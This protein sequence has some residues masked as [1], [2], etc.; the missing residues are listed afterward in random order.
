MH[1]GCGDG[2]MID[3]VLVVGLG[4]IGQRHLRLLRTRLPGS[5]I[6]VLRHGCCKTPVEGADV[7]VTSLEKALAF[8]PQIAVIATPAPFH[9]ETALALAEGGTHLL[10]EKPMAASALQAQA[11]TTA[12]QAA[13]VVLQVGYNLRQLSSLVAYRV[14]LHS[15]QIGRVA[16]VRAEV[17]QYLPDW[18]PGQDWR[19]SVS[20][21]ADLGGGVLLELS[22]EL[23]YLRWI[24]GD[25]CGVRGWVGQQ[26]GL[27]IDVEDTVHVLLNFSAATPFGFEGAA[28][29]A[30]LNMD[31]IRRDSV[32]R[33]VAIG[34]EGTLTWDGMVSEVRLNRP[35]AKDALLYC[36]RSDRDASYLAQI[37]SFL[38]SVEIGA[39]VAVSGND[40]LAVMH[41][42]DAVRHSHA[43]GGAVV[44]PARQD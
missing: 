29:V 30:S 2:A 3:R 36:N 14:A 9:Y 25:I 44:I 23:D 39:S 15:G 41:L 10:V 26:G 37:D 18:R 11:L 35:G 19:A 33:C 13:G 20:A 42:I 6:M 4:S 38:A 17:G 8:R 43:A 28:P 5:Q 22:H 16:S 7:C 34:E 40:G 27:A 31:F 21:R 24:F 12:A 1:R 32:R